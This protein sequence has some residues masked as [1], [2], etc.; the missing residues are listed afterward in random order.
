MTTAIAARLASPRQRLADLATALRRESG[1]FVLG[2]VVIAL[3]VLDDSFLQPA[4]GTSAGDHLISGLVPL[5][6]LA[7]AAWVYPRVRGGRRGALAC[8][9]WRSSCC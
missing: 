5:A 8:S 2:V 4:P 7:T 3:H 6:V 9:R 1:L